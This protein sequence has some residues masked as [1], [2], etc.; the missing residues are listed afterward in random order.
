MKWGDLLVVRKCAQR[1]EEVAD[2]LEQFP[3]LS[4]TLLEKRLRAVVAKGA[5]RMGLGV[6]ESKGRRGKGYF[7]EKKGTSRHLGA[8]DLCT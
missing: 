4:K 6:Q 1:G 5:W 3:R 7:V 8:G 2:V